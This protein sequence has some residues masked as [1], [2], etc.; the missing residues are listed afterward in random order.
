VHP[1]QLFIGLLPRPLLRLVLVLEPEGFTV[2]MFV[3]LAKLV[4]LPK[5]LVARLYASEL[6]FHFV[7][8]VLFQGFSLFKPLRYLFYNLVQFFYMHPLILLRRAQVFVLALLVVLC[9]LL[10]ERLVDFLQTEE[11]LV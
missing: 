1:I 8:E 3:Q 9:D 6:A 2:V 10:E 5:A 7:A 4:L 11:A